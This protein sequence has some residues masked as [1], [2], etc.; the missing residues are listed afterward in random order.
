MKFSDGSRNKY[1]RSPCQI[2]T[3]FYTQL[4]LFVYA[5]TNGLGGGAQTDFVLWRAKH[6]VRHCTYQHLGVGAR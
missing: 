1:T 4:T 6:Q 5:A 2:S 3:L